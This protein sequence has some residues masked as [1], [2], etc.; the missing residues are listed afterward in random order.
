M[1]QTTLLS[2]L[3]L[4]SILAAMIGCELVVDFDRTKLPQAP[5]GDAGT[6]DVVQP[7][8]VDA[9]VPPKDSAADA[10]APTDAE[11]PDAEVDAGEDAG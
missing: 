6:P 7:A 2:L 8:P 11:A 10:P 9:G 5:A 4:S 1:K 3:A